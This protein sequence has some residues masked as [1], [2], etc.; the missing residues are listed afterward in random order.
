MF[1][2]VFLVILVEHCAAKP[3]MRMPAL[4]LP[5]FLLGNIAQQVFA[6]MHVLNNR[7]PNRQVN[8][9][10]AVVVAWKVPVM[11]GMIAGGPSLGPRTRHPRHHMVLQAS[12]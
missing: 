11:K 3:V 4:E 1:C 5:F 12:H 6:K 7:D 2:V 8:V 9:G 10:I